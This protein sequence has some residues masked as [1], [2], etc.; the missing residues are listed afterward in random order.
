MVSIPQDARLERTIIPLWPWGYALVSAIALAA[1]LTAPLAAYVFLIALFGLPHVLCELRYCDERFSARAP[2]AALIAIGALLV[3]LAGLRIVQASGLVPAGVAVV[4]ELGLGVALAAAG[5]WF[6]P[7]RRA[8]GAFAGIALAAGTAFAP[9]M[10]FL[11][12]AWLHNLTPLAFVAE[13]VPRR[14]RARAIAA[15]LIPFVLVPAVI[16]SGLPQAALE[17]WLGYSALTA[18]SL[19]HAGRY[20]LLAFLPQRMSFAHA[21]PLF[22]AAVAAQ[23][24]H[25]LSVIVVMPR[26]LKRYGSISAPPS[27]WEGARGRDGKETQP[28]VQIPHPTPPPEGEGRSTRKNLVPWPSWRT[29][30]VAVGGLALGVFAGHAIDYP[31]ARAFYSVAAAI[32]SWVELPIFLIALGFGFTPAPPAQDR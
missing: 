21:L 23:A 6:M 19:F 18:P 27:L 1:V 25:Y 32:H 17:R 28:T 11:V 2:R 10:T 8:L 30:Y 15:L 13:I 5:V 14:E 7:R 12:I 31:N 22:S 16:A 20:P 24:M 3:V 29:F 4:A 26:L 9:I